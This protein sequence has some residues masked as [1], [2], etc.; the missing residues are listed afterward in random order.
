MKRLLNIIH[1]AAANRAGRQARQDSHPVFSRRQTIVDDRLAR[2]LGFFLPPRME[3]PTRSLAWSD[4]PTITAPVS[5]A[6]PA[7]PPFLHLRNMRLII[8][9]E[10]T[11]GW[12]L[13]LEISRNL[14]FVEYFNKLRWQNRTSFPPQAS[15]KSYVRTYKL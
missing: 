11:Q 1:A 9:T 13:L 10:F 5:A 7:N 3:N 8:Q 2:Q 6:Q 4:P 14:V 15:E 12:R